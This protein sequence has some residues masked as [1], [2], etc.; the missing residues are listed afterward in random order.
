MRRV[1]GLVCAVSLMLL[2]VAAGHAQ[3]NV[4]PAN[5]P[6][7]QQ[8]QSCSANQVCNSHC[9]CVTMQ[10]EPLNY[11]PGPGEICGRWCEC[12]Q[13]QAPSGNGDCAPCQTSSG[14]LC[15]RD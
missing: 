11:S 9:Q 3:T 15:Y 14:L 4:C 10:P 7:A 6:Q 2:A 8:Q 1:V 12:R 5:C 13:G